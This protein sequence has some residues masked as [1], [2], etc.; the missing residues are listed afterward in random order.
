MILGAILGRFFGMTISSILPITNI[1]RY[2]IAGAAALSATATRFL[3]MTL[4][5][6]ELT[7]DI[8][9]AFPI[10]ITVLFSFATGNLFTKTFFYSTIEWRKLPYVPKLMRKEIYKMKVRNIM[11]KPKIYLHAKS[12]FFDVFEFFARGKNICLADYIPVTV[13]LKDMTFVGTV[14]TDN[15]KSYFLE[16]LKM[17]RRKAQ[18]K[19]IRQTVY[20][21]K[22]YAEIDEEVYI[23]L[24]FSHINLIIN[25][26]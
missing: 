23:T 19:W 16:E 7:Q 11:Q 2:S 12:S 14:K 10:M 8:R 15:L 20:L 21:M 3:A 24:Y 18:G 26:L 1:G 22:S 17:Y 9:I 25:R 5:I 13:D 4:V 6:I